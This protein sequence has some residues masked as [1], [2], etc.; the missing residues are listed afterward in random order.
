[1]K[2][3]L[4]L[5]IASALTVGNTYAQKVIKEKDVTR[6]VSTLAS[7]DMMGRKP[8]TP[9]AL[10]AAQFI[11]DEF[12]KLNLQPLPGTMSYKQEFTKSRLIQ[13]SA[14][15]EVNGK[16]LDASVYVLGKARNI[17]WKKDTATYTEV[18]IQQPKDL[19]KWLY[20][21]S[22]LQHNVV[23]FM[24]PDMLEEHMAERLQY[25]SQKYYDTP[26]Q[27]ENIEAMETPYSVTVIVSSQPVSAADNW[28]LKAVRQI[29]SVPFTNVAAMIQGSSKPDEYV[30]FSSHYDHLGILPAVAGD[31]IANGADDDA[32]GTTAVIELA[33]YF[34]GTKPQRSLIFVAFTAEEMG[35][36]GSQYFSRKLDPNKVV[37]MFNIEMIGKES[38]FGKNSA[39]ITGFERSDFGT[40]LQRNLNGST[41]HF[42]PDPYPDQNL[43]YRSDNAT[44]ARLGVPAH[45]IST[46][47]IDKDTF[48]HTVKD[49]ISTL[50]MSNITSIIQAIA[51]SSATIVNGT[52]T[53]TR[54]K[55]T[56]E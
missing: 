18:Y 6:I 26:Q 43:F 30:V 31:S 1:M 7:D 56:Q 55:Q 44:L 40:I 53:P 36:Y 21:N 23:V 22:K 50:D 9:G 16:P 29:E 19:R 14:A 38:K 41:F 39:F 12:K 10:K 5:F 20:A 32:S 4:L 33:N 42:Y 8:G 25:I 52:D 45:T 3:K 24:T 17:D 13:Q 15:V 49:E 47:Q 48:Y 54:I 28:T 46:T 37:A 2:K 51:T 11:N 35:G 34:K 27:I